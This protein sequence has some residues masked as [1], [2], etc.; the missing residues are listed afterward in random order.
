MSIA[1]AGLTIANIWGYLWAHKRV[2]G[3]VILALTVT[4]TGFCVYKRV[5]RPK[6]DEKA[7]QRAENAIAERNTAELKEILAESD[8]KQE[9]IAGNV[10]NAEKET[11]RVKEESKKKYN[12][13]SLEDLAAELERRK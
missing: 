4:L 7:I 11:E 6:L 13:M 2:V 9:V 8:V 5:T 1:L 12:E 3:I 10:A